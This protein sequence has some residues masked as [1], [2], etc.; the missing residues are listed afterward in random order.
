MRPST[1]NLSVPRIFTDTGGL[2]L[3]RAAGGGHDWSRDELEEAAHLE[4]NTRDSEPGLDGVM[5]LKRGVTILARGSWLLGRFFFSTLCL[6]AFWSG[7][8][9]GGVPTPALARDRFSKR[10]RWADG[11]KISSSGDLNM[12]QGA[13]PTYWWLD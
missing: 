2:S 11:G 12:P 9:G 1:L 10:A 7:V 5:G 6:I 3:G 13:T 4:G 8:I